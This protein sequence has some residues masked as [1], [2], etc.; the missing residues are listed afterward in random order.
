MMSR[1]KLFIDLKAT[2][3]RPTSNC[4][5]PTNASKVD[6]LN[7]IDRSNLINMLYESLNF[8]CEKDK[9]SCFD[10]MREVID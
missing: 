7:Q 10:H 1:D 4:N 8:D 3:N 9:K 6:I 2:P 5:P